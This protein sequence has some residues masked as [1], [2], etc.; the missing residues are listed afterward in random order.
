MERLYSY[1]LYIWFLI[2]EERRLL[3]ST[4]ENLPLMVRTLPLHQNDRKRTLSW[5]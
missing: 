4:Y 5:T 2:K 3:K 1:F